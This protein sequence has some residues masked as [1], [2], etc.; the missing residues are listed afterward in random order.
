MYKHVI[1]ADRASMAINKSGIKRLNMFVTI[2]SYI[3]IIGNRYIG[4]S[5]YVLRVKIIDGETSMKIA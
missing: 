5:E 1:V 2:N 4:V 3:I